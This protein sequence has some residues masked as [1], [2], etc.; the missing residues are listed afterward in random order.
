MFGLRKYFS[1][2]LV[3]AIVI[4]VLTLS[5]VWAQCP[6]AGRFYDKIFAFDSMEVQYTTVRSDFNKMDVFLPVND[7]AQ[8]R[9]LLLL[10]HGGGFNSGDKNT[11]RAVNVLC[12]SFAQRGFVTASIQYRLTEA[13]NLIDSVK[14]MYAVLNA[15]YDAKA[16]VR[17]FVKDAATANQFRIDSNYIFIGG[18][19]AGAVLSI[20]YAYL[21]DLSEV[22]AVL[23]DS[24]LA[25]GGLEGDAGNPG[26][27]SSVKAAIPMAGGINRLWWIGDDEEPMLL[28]HGDKDRTI[29]YFFDQVY[30]LPPYNF[31]T[32]ITLYGSGSIDTALNNRGIY[33][34]LKTYY[35]YDHTPWDTSWAL[36]AEI[37]TIARDFLYPMI[38]NDFPLP[39][40]DDFKPVRLL[41]VF[42]NPVFQELYAE[43]NYA[44]ISRIDVFN[45]MG[46][47]IYTQQYAN[48]AQRQKLYT[49]RWVPG[50]YIVYA[51]DDKGSPLGHKKI[52]IKH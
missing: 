30:R 27:S 5:E 46:E 14:M 51:A 1:G 45:A 18:S 3:P 48:A 52:I 33:H 26:Y 15:I 19:S 41:Q 39:V 20:H 36:C 8:R 29:P 7:D 49:G 40:P 31:F 32:L 28:I 35:D 17:F 9:P 43:S 47:K 12:R 23:L 38:C 11:D 2:C 4:A 13:L 22:P 21:D 44:P 24:V 37:D 25:H 42:P 6:R 34:Q 16:A 10:A 50:L